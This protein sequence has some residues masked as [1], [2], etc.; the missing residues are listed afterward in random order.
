MFKIIS[1]IDDVQQ[2]VANKKE[3]RFLKQPNGL[4]I[5]CYMFMDSKTFDT[6][7]SLECRGIAFD[8]SGRVVSRPL[9]KFFN[10]GEKTSLAP[11]HL[12]LRDDIAAIYEKL[13][14][15]MIATALVN[16]EMVLRSKKSFDSDVVKMATDFLGMPE[17][18][19]I[20]VFSNKVA[21]GGMTAV[22]EFTHPSARIVVAQDRPQLRLL[23]VRDNV[24]GDYVMLDPNHVIHEL[25]ANHG[26]PLVQRFDGLSLS[27]AIETLVNMEGREGYVIQFN[28]GD[29]AKI[30]CPW[31]LRLHRSITFL[32]ERDI[33]LLAIN[34]EL[35]DLK[36]VLIEA[37]I[38]ISCVNEVESRLK[39]I[40]SGLLDEIEAIYEKSR[41]LDRKS[42]AVANKDHLLFGLAMQRYLGQE[43]PLAEWYGRKMLKNDFSLRVLANDAL[44]EAMEV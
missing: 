15:S 25:I 40:L 24:T 8:S 42:F 35:D 7:E 14:G 44:A 20:K 29:M 43:V 28:N 19:E 17:N 9:H 4:T 41:G 6:P 2:V 12:L 32:R 3:I 10:V 21:G 22:F 34:E 39:G 38:D 31:Y 18:S 23:H 27:D 1:H 13:D 33:A 26:V 16:G 37:G 30:K 36:G 11:D 5:G